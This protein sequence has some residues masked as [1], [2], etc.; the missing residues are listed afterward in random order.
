M[1]SQ[2][3]VCASSDRSARDLL[4]HRSV[5][6]FAEPLKRADALEVGVRNRTVK[7]LILGTTFIAGLA[8]PATALAQAKDAPV[9]GAGLSFLRDDG[10]TATGVT[11]DLAQTIHRTGAV[12]IGAVGDVSFNH[13]M[14]DAT[15]GATGSAAASYIGGVRVGGRAQRVRPYAQFTVGVEHCCGS[16]DFAFAPAVGVDIPVNRMLNVRA[17]VDFRTVVLTDSHVNEQRYWFG[18]SLPLGAK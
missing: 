9:V 13:F 6:S 14:A 10:E 17:Q 5:R 8:A 18:V 12:A 11:F 2:I 16:S 15:T 7:A 3:A 1:R 4:R